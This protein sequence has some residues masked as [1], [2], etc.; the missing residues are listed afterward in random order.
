MG[1]LFDQYPG[2][3]KKGSGITISN[4]QEMLYIS[5]RDEVFLYTGIC[6]NDEDA[7]HKGLY[8]NPY[9]MDGLHSTD[10]A[11]RDRIRDFYRISDGCI[12]LDEFV[13]GLC[14]KNEKYK[15][16]NGGVFLDTRGT[17]Y[18]IQINHQN[19]AALTQAV[20]GLTVAELSTLVEASSKVMSSTGDYE[21]FPRLTRSLHK[22]N[23]CELTGAWIP[24]KF[25]YIAFSESGYDFSHVS[26]WGFYRMIQ[27]LTYTRMDS[28]V[29][30]AY[31]EAGI[32]KA[33]LNRVFALGRNIMER[34]ICRIE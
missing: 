27:M 3:G 5:E 29:S 24:A 12:Y 32:D 11:I 13:D 22:D 10:R 23:Y 1:I 2:T 8:F 9:T 31:M 15:Q 28:K 25:P 26:I 6:V 4:K 7:R 14:Y 19:D 16:I 34:K 20:F 21:W 30:K 18:G 33:L 17:D